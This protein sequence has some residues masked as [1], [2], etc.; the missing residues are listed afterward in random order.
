MGLLKIIL[1]KLPAD[2]NKKCTENLRESLAF[3]TFLKQ[4]FLVTQNLY[5]NEKID[6]IS[7]ILELIEINSP[8][9]FDILRMQQLD[10]KLINILHFRKRE[11][12]NLNFVSLNMLNSTIFKYLTNQQK[13][14]FLKIFLTEF[15]KEYK[16][17][18]LNP[19]FPDFFGININN[20]K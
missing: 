8:I 9:N 11:F 14:D 5:L 10:I 15:S 19:K 13:L 2:Y 12:N 17:V 1:R 6:L 3:V 7:I 4:Y 18:D 20:D 16:V